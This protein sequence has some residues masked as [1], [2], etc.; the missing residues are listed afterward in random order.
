M[1]CLKWL[2][3]L[4]IIVL[5]SILV[6]LDVAYAA[7]PSI[8]DVKVYQDYEQSGDWL[9]VAVYNISGGNTTTSL[10][11]TNY[12]WTF[13]LIDSTG[14]ALTNT[15]LE[16]CGMRVV[17]VEISQ[18]QASA[19]TWNGNY[20]VKIIGNW[21]TAPSATRAINNS[22]WRGSDLTYLDQWVQDEAGIIQ[23]FD[24]QT[25]SNVSYIE[26]VYTNETYVQS[27]TYSGGYIFS[28]IPAFSHYRPELFLITTTSVPIQYI[29]NST[30]MTYATNLYGGFNASVGTTVATALA[31]VAPYV[32]FTG[33]NAARMMGM[34]LTLIGF[35][36]VAMIEKSIAFMIILGGVMIGVFPMA[37]V[38]VLVFILII[39]LVRSLFWSST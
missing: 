10:C 31:T 30:D 12:P 6:P 9:I 39:L 28:A 11:G 36:A 8:D 16:Q 34:I 27:L 38:F 15:S 13:Q 21:G 5:I 4:S 20:S 18:A 3:I 29:N 2:V 33:V 22:D 37:T 14:T 17:G 32:G 24:A 25:Y 7:S 26:V 19:Y 35:F 23:N 1:K